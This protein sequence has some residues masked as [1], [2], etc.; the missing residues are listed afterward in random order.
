MNDH[1]RDNHTNT[2]MQVKDSPEEAVH[3]R[4]SLCLPEDSL[5]S[6]II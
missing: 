2:L 4:L 5:L 3:S 6:H 1:Q